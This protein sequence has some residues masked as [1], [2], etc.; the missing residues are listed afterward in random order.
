MLYAGVY[1]CGGIELLF[2]L[3]REA[4][5]LAHLEHIPILPL[6]EVLGR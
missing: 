4:G 2:Y 6:R 5:P 3:S 1:T